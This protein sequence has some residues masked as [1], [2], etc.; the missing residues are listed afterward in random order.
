MPNELTPANARWSSTQTRAQFSAIA[1][2]RWR[3]LANSF[4]RKGGAGELIGRIIVYPLFA[5]LA[6]VPTVGVGVGAFFLAYKN[7]LD[8]VFWLCWVTFGLCQLL[9]IQLGQPGTTF[10]PTQ[11]IRFPMRLGSFTAVRLFFGLLSPANIIGTLMSFS[12]A[13]GIAIAKP[14]LW[15][16]AFLALAVFAAAN[17]LFSRMIFAWVD[18]W[19]STRR[20][21][22]VFTG[23]IFVFSLGIQWANFTFNP[24]YNRHNGHGHAQSISSDRL[25]AAAHLYQ[26]V[27]PLMAALPPGLTGNSLVAASQGRSLYFLGDTLGCAL[28][29]AVFLAVF[30][31]RMRTEFRGENLSDAANAVSR[32]P[33]KS[34][35]LKP[36]SVRTNSAVPLPATTS[37]GFLPPVVSA[38]LGKEFLYVRRNTGIFY[39][40]VAPIVFVFLFAGRL[41]TRGNSAWVFP[42][43]VA[44]TMLGI[45][46]LAYNSFG[47]EGTG[48]QFY[49]LA[50]IDLREV[51]LAKNLLNFLLSFIEIAAV[52]AIVSY[53][54][55]MPSPQTVA[56]ALLWAAAT[57]LV[58]TMLGNYRSIT[59]PKKVNI[60]RSAGKQASPLSGLIAMGV[61]LLS[62]S[63][64][65]GLLILAAYF[66]RTWML[67]PLFAVFAATALWFYLRSLRTLDSFARNRREDLFLELTKKD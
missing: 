45:T 29:A 3:I 6:L 27:R 39:S 62:A 11:L 30:M 58:G 4:R 9:N 47:L 67:V 66:H 26:H 32:A 44:Y 10:D 34:S 5:F 50:P 51:F 28:F 61:L 20:A 59:A 48:S 23:L 24:A 43:A 21:R 38:M 15:A 49:F 57:L 60:A 14:G 19:L 12:I 42:A 56:I 53:V 63:I 1:W 36:A 41:A 16:Y 55:T 65:A 22:E 31:L 37:R 64:G 52:F 40:L 8:S 46:P 18:R 35:K 7:N 2:L 33:K 13:L 54:A 17:V 25:N